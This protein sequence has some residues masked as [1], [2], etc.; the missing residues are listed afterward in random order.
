M[1][2][3]SASFVLCAALGFSR[4]CVGSY[5]VNMIDIAPDNAE[6]IMSFSNTLG[7]FPGIIGNVVTGAI[8]TSTGSWSGVFAVTSVVYVI[9]GIVFLIFADDQPIL[10]QQKRPEKE[11]A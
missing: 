9:G 1:S 7:T 11:D 5:W 3:S 6:Q 4:L 2:A 8:L 10:Q